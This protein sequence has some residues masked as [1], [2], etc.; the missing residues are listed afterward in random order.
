MQSFPTLCPESSS[1]L[2][3]IHNDSSSKLCSFYVCALLREFPEYFLGIWADV[4]GG[5]ENFSPVQEGRVAVAG[6]EWG[7]LRWRSPLDKRTDLRIRPI[8]ERQKELV[9]T[10]ILQRLGNLTEKAHF[11]K[12]LTNLFLQMLKIHL[13]WELNRSVYFFSQ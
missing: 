1:N 6:N 5:R 3:V 13:A 12:I 8:V 2:V 4:V 9:A 10:W 11:L 7:R